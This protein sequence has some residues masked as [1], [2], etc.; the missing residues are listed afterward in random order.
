[1]TFPDMLSVKCSDSREDLA[2]ASLGGVV[3]CFAE[4][5]VKEKEGRKLV[6]ESVQAECQ[7]RMLFT[8]LHSPPFVLERCDCIA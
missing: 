1:M 7:V 4:L 2:F 8:S 5:E 3:C 6:F